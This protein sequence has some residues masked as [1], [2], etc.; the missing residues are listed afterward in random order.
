[1]NTG[2]IFDL[3]GTLWEVIDAT[4]KAVNEVAIKNGFEPISRK[5][6]CDVFGTPRDACAKIYFPTLSV[7]EA[8]SLMDEST[9]KNIEYLQKYGGNVFAKVKETMEELSKKYELFI[10]SNTAFNTY[11]EAF[12]NCSGT[13]EL[14]TDYI[15]TGEYNLTKPEAIKK[16]VVDH[17]LDKSIYVGDTEKDME[18]AIGAGVE[19]IQAKYGFGQDLKT[20]HSID[21]IEELPKKISVFDHLV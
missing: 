17:N 10:V 14:F 3:D 15:A 12:L 1:M 5:T 11:I 2:I 7:E 6:I 9:I 18:A 16:I 13:K 20:A 19:F 4:H 21:K 8:V